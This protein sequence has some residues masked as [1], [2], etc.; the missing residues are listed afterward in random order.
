M[1]KSLPKKQLKEFLQKVMNNYELII[2][3]QQNNKKFKSAKTKKDLDML[4]LKNITEVPVKKYFLPE[5]ETLVEFGKGKVK[6]IN[7]EIKKRVIFGLRR[8]DLNALIVLDK[9]MKDPNYIQKRKNTILIGMHCENPDEYCFCNSME[10]QEPNKKICDLFFYPYKNKYYISVFT[11]IGEKIVKG[12]PKVRKNQEVRKKIKNIKTLKDKDIQRHY[13]NKIWESDAEKCLSCSACTVYCPTCNCFDIKDKQNINLKD[14][15][16][17]RNEA[18]CQLQS[19]SK[20]AGGRIFRESRL[21][22][23]KH[24]VYHKISYFKKQYNMYMCVGCGRCLRV[25]PTHIDWVKTINLLQDSDI[26][27]NK[28]KN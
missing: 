14:S 27:K 25:C 23:F 20:V 17:I 12:L 6:K 26:M 16:R 3:V 2:P 22:R 8:C 21:S 4:F 7:K 5:N 13:K 24:F 18:S 15:K 28:Q 9:V 1:Q 10:L 11:K 19:F